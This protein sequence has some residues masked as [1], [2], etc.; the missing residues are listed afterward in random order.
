M[1]PHT[2]P[3]DPNYA[4]CPAYGPPESP[5]QIRIVIDGVPGYARRTHPR[6]RGTSL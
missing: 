5:Q 1:S 4:F 3:D 2:L 6:R